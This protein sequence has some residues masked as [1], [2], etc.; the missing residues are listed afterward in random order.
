MR[1]QRCGGLSNCNDKLKSMNDKLEFIG[2]GWSFPPAFDHVSGN[3]A[4]ST[5]V[6]D[7][8]ESLTILLSTTLG[9]RVMRP[10]YGCNL[11]DYVFDPMN[12]SLEAYIKKLVEDAIIYFEPRITLESVT[13]DFRD[14]EGVMWIKVDFRID[15]TNSR[16][17]YVYPFYIKEGTNL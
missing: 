8:F 16:A 12:V 4:M 6:Q 5:G 15:A 7:I 1:R 17:N 2:T 3:T 14:E 13:A 10:D 11:K 9:E